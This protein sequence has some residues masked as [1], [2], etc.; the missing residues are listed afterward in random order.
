MVME[1]KKTGHSH[2]RANLAPHTLQG[3]FLHLLRS[4]THSRYMHLL[5]SYCV[6]GSVL[7]T[8]DTK[9]KKVQAPPF[10]CSQSEGDSH[11]QKLTAIS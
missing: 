9:I 4:F 10:R 3:A 7:G 1:K 11:A 5:S 2:S 6:L 8:G